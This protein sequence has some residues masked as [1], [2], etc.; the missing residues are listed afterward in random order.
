MKEIL[1][2]YVKGTI[3]AGSQDVV[4]S[5][6]ITSTKQEINMTR[7]VFKFDSEWCGTDTEELFSFDDSY[8]ENDIMLELED[9]AQTMSVELLDED[10]AYDED[11]EPQFYSD[12][13][14]L[15]PGEEYIPG[16]H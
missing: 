8:T 12:Y 2:V 9:W 4:G 5:I 6:P 14:I 15:A 11:G 7:V 1:G 3:S 13:I 16:E 10:E